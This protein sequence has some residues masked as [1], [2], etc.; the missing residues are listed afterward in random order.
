MKLAKTTFKTMALAV[1]LTVFLWSLQACEEPD[2][3][4]PNT[5]ECNQNI[6]QTCDEEGFWFEINNCTEFDLI[7]CWVEPK[8]KFQCVSECE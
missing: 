2:G 1:F 7:C 4:E 8:N 5:T 3:C 6:L